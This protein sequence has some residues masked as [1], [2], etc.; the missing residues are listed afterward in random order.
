MFGMYLLSC[1]TPSSQ[2]ALLILSCSALALSHQEQRPHTPSL[3]RPHYPLVAIHVDIAVCDSVLY[4]MDKTITLVKVVVEEQA[5]DAS[6]STL[7]III[8]RGPIFIME[9]DKV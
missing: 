5:P 3:I 2:V 6:Y 9:V 4:S 7:I 1:L 8:C